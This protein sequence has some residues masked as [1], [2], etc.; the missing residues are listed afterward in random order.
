MGAEKPSC[1]VNQSSPCVLWSI[2]S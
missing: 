1:K 2:I